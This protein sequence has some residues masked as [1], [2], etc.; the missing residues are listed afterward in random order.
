MTKRNNKSKF[1]PLLA[2]TTALSGLTLVAPGSLSAAQA[3]SEMEMGG[4]EE[5]V[6]KARKREES[7]QDIPV[8][9]S[10]LT[11]DQIQRNDLTSLEKIAA[12]TPQFTVG[13]ASSGSGAQMSMR[14]IG[15]NSTSIGIEQSVAAVV[16]GAFSGQGRV[17]YQGFFDLERVEILRGPQ[18]L[19]FGK[20]ATAGV[21]SIETK[22]PGDELEMIGRVGYEVGS[23]RLTGEGIVSTPLSDTLGLRIAVR[24]LKM[25]GGYYDNTSP[26]IP[27]QT[28]DIATGNVSNF[29]APVSDK[30]MPRE[31]ELISR[32][33]LKW[34]PTDRL[35]GTLKA[36][37]NKNEVNN[38][39]WNYVAFAC[40]TGFSTLSP[41]V[42]CE[43]DVFE[44]HQ[45]D[46]PAAIAA[47]TDFAGDGSLYNDFETYNLTATIDYE[48]DDM[49]LT[50]ISY[51]NNT[52]NAW[53][54]NCAYQTGPIWATEDSSWEAYSNETR[55]VTDYD[56]PLNMLVGLYYQNTKR[57]FDQNVLFAGSENSNAPD[58]L[59]YVSYR[60]NSKTDGETISVFG[61]AT[62]NFLPDFELAGGVRY[63]RETKDSFFVQPY[64]NPGLT[65]LFVEG[66][67]IRADQTFTNWSPEATLS[68][69]ASED[70]TVYG[71]YKTAYKSGGLSNSGIFSAL[72][73]TPEDDFIFEPEEAKGFE[74]GVKTTLMENQL[75]LN[76]TAYRYKF[77]NLQVDFFNAPTFA[78]LTINAGSSVS[79]GIET[80]FQ[81][82]PRDVPGLML[83][84]SLNY[85]RARYKEFTGPCYSGQSVAAGCPSPTGP[86]GF[87]LQDLSGQETAVAPDWT[88]T[89]GGYYETSVSDGY[90]LGLGANLRYSDDYLAS[91]LGSEL[92]R[93][94]S[95]VT[96][97]A[98][99]RLMSADDRWE[100][101]V[102]GKNLTDKQ[103][104]LG[105]QDG[106]AT[107][108][109]TGTVNGIAADQI[110][111][112][113]TPRT[114]EFQMTFRY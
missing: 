5:I 1:L 88:A 109:G 25:W 13:R 49:T 4:L 79:K 111:Y 70:V 94:S 12:T 2:A 91:N 85:N 110:G 101:A 59:R 48:F 41:D 47:E 89:L 77:T 63:L 36:T 29:V 71:A 103:Y 66:E 27:Y 6:V 10:A 38:N 8:A 97:D 114:V 33:T 42:P 50:S 64:V 106:P 72:S 73:T 69:Q 56:G 3:Q 39:S 74:A 92:S 7:L 76:L 11:A 21:V 112:G 96:I 43:D 86:G 75:R 24:G 100:F 95:Y 99:A 45:N 26:E 65:A 62:W 90:N 40:A 61:Q 28:I 34:T 9:V 32:I 81:Y 82:A 22:D 31:E 20:N 108:S 30:E 51:Y 80:E 83:N 107:G 37:Y 35:T 15:S 60:K 23:E 78:F 18:A 57:T 44:V 98:T 87:P 104:F 55:L 53:N 16:D 58:G 93:V 113:T 52:D 54:C 19:F 67:F 84:G 46:L 14:G 68:W 105:M 102:I 17:I